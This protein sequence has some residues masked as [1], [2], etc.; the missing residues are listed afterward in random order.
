MF[1]LAYFSAADSYMFWKNGDEKTAEIISLSDTKKRNF[2][3]YELAIENVRVDAEFAFKLPVGKRIK[4]LT[5]PGNPMKVALGTKESNLYQIFSYSIGGNFMAILT[6]CVFGAGII[7]TPFV[8]P[9]LIKK[10]REFIE[11]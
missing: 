11:Q 4:V 8:L 1:G 10:R 5:L 3:T 7:C 6:I 9:E 2:I